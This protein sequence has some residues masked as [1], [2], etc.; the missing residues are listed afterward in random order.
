MIPLLAFVVLA[1]LFA[2]ALQCFARYYQYLG[3]ELKTNIKHK[4]FCDFCQFFLL[5]LL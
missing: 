2:S 4:L 3:S 1:C 5:L